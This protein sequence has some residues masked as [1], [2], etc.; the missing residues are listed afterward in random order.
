MTSLR[1]LLELR[2]AGQPLPPV[3]EHNARRV[4][5]PVCLDDGLVHVWHPRSVDAARKL[6]AEAGTLDAL[7]VLYSAVAA[8]T[9][10]RGDAFYSRD[11]KGGGVRVRMARFSEQNF[12]R[13]DGQPTS[14]SEKAKLATWIQDWRPAN[15]TQSFDQFNEAGYVNADL[16]F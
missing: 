16:G 15:Y 1:E 10:S 5:C 9:C 6:L 14:V 2:M 12:C 3:D 13:L 7:G 8:C 11:V 4:Y